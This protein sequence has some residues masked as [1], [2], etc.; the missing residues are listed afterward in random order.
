MEKSIEE[1]DR[2]RQKYLESIPKQALDAVLASSV[3]EKID[4]DIV[5]GNF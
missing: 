3:S 2:E 1:K 4:S 5:K